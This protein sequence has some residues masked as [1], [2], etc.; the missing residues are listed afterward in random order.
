MVKKIAV[1]ALLVG[2]IFGQN[3][4]TKAATSGTINVSSVNERY[5]LDF[6]ANTQAVQNFYVDSNTIYTTQRVTE[7]NNTSKKYVR[8]TKFSLSSG[9]PQKK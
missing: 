1:C 3:E 7:A 4:I 2:V 6:G 8:I 9:V 5:T